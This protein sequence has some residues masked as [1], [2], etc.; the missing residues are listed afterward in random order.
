MSVIVWDGKT[1]A[2]DK[3]G[4]NCEMRFTECKMAVKFTEH[5]LV[6]CAWTGTASYGRELAQWYFDGAVKEKWPEFQKDK[7]DWCRLIVADADGCQF[8]EM[9]PFPMI[10]HDPYMAW[11][12]GRDFAMGALAM[13][14]DAITAVEVACKFSTGCGYG[15][16]SHDMT[17]KAQLTGGPALSARPR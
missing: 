10:V 15:V 8:Y 3:Q 14:A 12:S 2:A 4:T 5:G 11:G 16:E 7:D 13:G 1:L 9:T 17:H 6:A